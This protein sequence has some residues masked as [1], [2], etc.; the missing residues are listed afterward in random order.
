LSLT[1][2]DKL[3]LVVS[4]REKNGVEAWNGFS[5]STVTGK[6]TPATFAP[7]K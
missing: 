4:L 3:K 1:S 7:K 6:V 5:F 2:G